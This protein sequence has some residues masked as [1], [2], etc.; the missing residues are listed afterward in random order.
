MNAPLSYRI[1]K[2]LGE[3][4]LTGK[5]LIQLKNSVE[6][7]TIVSRSG[8]LTPIGGRGIQYS[9]AAVL[10]S[11]LKFVG[12]HTTNQALFDKIVFTLIEVTKGQ[13]VK[14]LLSIPYML[15]DLCANPAVKMPD[16]SGV[17]IEPTQ[18]CPSS[19]FQLTSSEKEAL[20][21][22]SMHIDGIISVV[23]SE[24][25][26]KVIKKLAI[27]SCAKYFHTEHDYGWTAQ[28][29]KGYANR[30]RSCFE[31]LLK[32]EA[33]DKDVKNEISR[34]LAKI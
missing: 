27:R 13:H 25:G 11:V 3:E 10:Y 22:D 31:E 14:G 34:L 2:E 7:P 23:K 20:R 16:I 19:E 4:E 21:C 29:N 33:V 17:K 5:I 8:G 6:P 26:D 28:Q 30:L 1:W 15:S 24:H 12:Y 9:T 32:D 18:S